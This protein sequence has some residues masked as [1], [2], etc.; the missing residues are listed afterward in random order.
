M[1]PTTSRGAALQ[2]LDHQAGFFHRL[3]G[4]PGQVAHFVGDHGKATAGLT[5]AGGFDGCV[6][7]QQVGLLGDAANHFEHR[8]DLLAVGRP[9]LQP[10]P[11][12]CSCPPA[13]WPMLVVVRSITC[14][15]SRVA[16]SASRAACGG[17]GGTAGD[18]L[19]GGAHFMGG[20]GHLVDLAVLLLHAG[21][22]L[23]GDG[24]GLVGGA[25]G[26]LHR[27]VSPRR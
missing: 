15:P 8:A 6:E 22:G 3:L 9:G 17:L 16:W 25:A 4:A 13:R 7:G 18:V 23:A 11:W 26:V 27:A 24:G 21:A 19:G 1:A 14:R 5:G 2:L 20:G 10:G 12:R